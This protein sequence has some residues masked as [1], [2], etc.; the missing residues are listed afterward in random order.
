MGQESTWQRR[1]NVLRY[2]IV[3]PVFVV[4][5]TFA[6]QLLNFRANPTVPFTIDRILG[7]CYA[8][9]MMGAFMLW[10]AIFLWIPSEKYQ[11]PAT[12]FGYVPVY[13]ANGFM[14]YWVTMVTY[15]GLHF[16][17]PDLS[18]DVYNNMAHIL[19]ALNLLALTFC[20]F[21]LV[22]GICRP[23]SNEKL[24]RM[25]VMYEFYRGMEIHPRLF[26]FDVKQW[27]NC[28]V[29][30]MLWQ[31][32]IVA[33]VM[34]SW[35]QTGSWN[36]GHVVNVA[37]Q[38][39]YIAKFF[40]WETGYFTT[41][42]IT[43]DRA[44]YYICWGCLVWVPLFYT[45]SSFCAVAFMPTMTGST[46]V[47]VMLIGLAAVGMNYRVDYEKQLFRQTGGKCTLW[48]QPARGLTVRNQLTDK[49]SELLLSGCWGVSRHLN[50]VFELM[51]ALTWC[52]AAAWG[53]DLWPLLY[54]FFLVVLLV[55][56]VFRDEEK[57]AAKYGP[58]WTQY[59]QLV[60]YRMIPYIF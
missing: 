5:F 47:I 6:V 30:M 35:R 48:G 16:F 3:P 51:A 17:Y 19:G 49:P 54:F 32:L 1:Y 43:L 23:Q 7:N 20:V 45:Y 41:L 13:S 8:W 27:T 44:G 56:R 28:R 46:A 37:L 36:A 18:L 14:Y 39:V 21:L 57:C 40:W 52:S 4:F 24:T 34:A 9:K 60:P 58:Y 10:A 2:Q 33:F 26:G 22:I 38:T 12:N 59:C 11:G 25:P 15:V 42:D 29:G 53:H 55:H 31:V 50:Y